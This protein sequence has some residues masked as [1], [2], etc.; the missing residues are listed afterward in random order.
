LKTK[1]LILVV[2]ALIA[3][4]MIIS[5]QQVSALQVRTVFDNRHTCA[6]FGDS[7]ICGDHICAKGEKTNRFMQYGVHN[8]QTLAQFLLPRM[9]GYNV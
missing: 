6:T 5:S 3:F 1:V 4:M 8:D 2:F 9:V 7:K